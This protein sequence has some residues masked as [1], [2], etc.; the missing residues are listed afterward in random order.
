MFNA[1]VERFGGRGE[2][3]SA[4]R[5]RRRFPLTWMKD[6]TPVPAQ[7]LEIST[8]GVLFATKDAPSTRD[9][10]VRIGLANRQVRARLTI[11]RSGTMAREGVEW[12]IL[13]GVFQGIAADDWDSIVR[14]CKN[15][16]DPTNKAAD[17][18]ASMAHGDD[19]AYRL[20]PLK[21]QERIVA[22]LV[23]AGR[24][25]PGSDAKNPLLRMTYGGKTRTGAHVLSVRSRRHVDGEAVEF[26]SSLQVDES[27]NVRLDR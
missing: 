9:L 20:L 17:E 1:L 5:I 22:T 24:L 25:N 18:L 26:D 15:Q 13:A 14:F 8:K 4:D 10:E 7:G 16:P 27:G 6:G 2:R 19:D 23:E 12:T 3:R 11:A 21:V